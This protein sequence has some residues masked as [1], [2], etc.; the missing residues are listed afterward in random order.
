MRICLTLVLTLLAACGTVKG[1][2]AAASE[3]RDEWFEIG[4]E[5][6]EDNR[7]LRGD[8][9]FALVSPGDIE[10]LAQDGSN[11]AEVNEFK[12]AL[13]NKPGDTLHNLR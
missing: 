7:H 13:K 9:G 3:A 2:E 4:R 11:P 5:G 6:A 10:S 8:E 1:M 12:E